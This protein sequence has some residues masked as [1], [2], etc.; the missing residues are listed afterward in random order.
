MSAL[1]INHYDDRKDLIS[2]ALV[3]HDFESLSK[4]EKMMTVLAHQ[5]DAKGTS[6][7][8]AD[9]QAGSRARVEMQASLQTL[10]TEFEAD[11]RNS[12]YQLEQH[13]AARVS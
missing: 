3:D 11:L 7:V 6:K 4:M 13:A 10:R 5:Q 12:L 1:H 8:A 9:E 2:Q